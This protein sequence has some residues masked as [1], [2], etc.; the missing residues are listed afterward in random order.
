MWIFMFLSLA[1]FT[2]KYELCVDDFN[3]AIESLVLSWEKT[4]IVVIYELLI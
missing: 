1:E 3:C 4:V 2:I